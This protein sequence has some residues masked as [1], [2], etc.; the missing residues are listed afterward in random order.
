MKELQDNGS[1]ISIA[2][3]IEKI[4]QESGKTF[5]LEK[6]N[7]A[8]IERLTGIS[9]SRLR[10]LQKNG[11]QDKETAHKGTKHKNTKLTGF[12]ELIDTLLQ[13]GTSNSNVIYDH[14]KDEGFTGGKT[15]VKEYIAAHR[16][17]M[18]AKR[19]QVDPQGNR[20]RRYTSDPGECF[21]MDWGFVKVLDSEGIESQAA[22]FAMICHH[23]AVRYIEFFPN[24]SQENLFIG[25]IHAFSYLGVPQTVL[26]D[27]MKSV[28]IRRDSLGCPLWQK[29]YEAFMKEIGF[30]TKLC[31][32]R[33]PFTKGAVERL[34]RFVKDNFLQSRTFHNLTDLNRQALDWCN[35]QNGL[36]RKA[37][38]G[39]PEKIHAEHCADNLGVLT[40]SDTVMRWLC[41]L[42]KISFDGFVSF[43]GRRYGVPYSY[44][45]KTVHVKRDG[46]TLYIYSENLKSL[47]TKH[48][49][50]WERTD[51]FCEHQYEAFPQPEEQPTMPVK[52]QIRQ[53]FKPQ[54]SLSFEKFNFDVE[55]DD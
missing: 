9:R 10:T 7:L 20:G 24:A 28:V 33:H 32:P 35:T 13:S 8:E 47:L 50:T 26:T 44:T 4:K 40:V 18:P 31:K 3:A 6:I 39:I 1:T 14:L 42:R 17:L 29:D 41:P 51:N 45:G 15:I 37:S 49:V 23:C 54:S 16:Y 34:V 21:Q 25:M 36:Y 11:F 55:D 12:T 27:N 19:Q 48:S 43:E 30:E 52:T 2:Q 5:R 38:A 53:I 46:D 22:C